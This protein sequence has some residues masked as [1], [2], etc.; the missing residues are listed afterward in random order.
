MEL[1]DNEFLCVSVRVGFV[2]I[3]LYRDYG[4]PN[5]RYEFKVA[6][7]SQWETL[8]DN[9]GVLNVITRMLDELR[10]TDFLR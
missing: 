1:Y 6:V 2:R 7:I 5:I 3:L 9:E 10:E 8:C 4:T